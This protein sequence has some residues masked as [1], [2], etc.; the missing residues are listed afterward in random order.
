MVFFI[1]FHLLE[2]TLLTQVWPL[3]ARIEH[4]ETRKPLEVRNNE[5]GTCAAQ[6]V[7]G[8]KLEGLTVLQLCAE[9]TFEVRVVLDVLDCVVQD[10]LVAAE[11]E[12]FCNR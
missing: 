8:S 2:S 12:L 4:K 6:V 5:L 7:L 11:A 3:R 1:D 9:H 10:F